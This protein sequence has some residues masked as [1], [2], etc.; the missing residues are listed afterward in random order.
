MNSKGRLHPFGLAVNG[1]F[2]YMSD[3][4]EK[5]VGRIR[6][7]AVQESNCE[8]LTERNASLPVPSDLAVMDSTAEGN[9]PEQLAW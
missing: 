5:F 9:G 6:N 4:S 1:D 8:A 2:V 3:F 7:T